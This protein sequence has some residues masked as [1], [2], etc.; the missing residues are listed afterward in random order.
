MNSTAIRS[1]RVALSPAA[2]R[3]V[4]PIKPKDIPRADWNLFVHLN[5]DNNL[6]SFGKADLNEMERV[7]SQKGKFNVFA[8]VDGANG[9]APETG[10]WKQGTRLMW[11]QRDPAKSG[12]IVSREIWVD[13]NSDLGKLLKKGHGELNMGNPAVLNAAL[14]YVQGR[15]PSKSTMVDLWDHGDGWKMASYDESGSELNPV[16][17]EL[18]SALKGVK[19]D[20]LGFDECLMA[21]K[22][23][24][25]I[26]Q[27]AGAKYLVGSEHTEPGEGWNY[28]DFLKRFSNL[29]G[30][31]EPVTADKVAKAA[32]RSYAAGGAKNTQMSATD[33][34]QL[35]SLTRAVDA[36]ADQIFAAGGFKSAAVKDAYENAH[37]GDY[38]PDQ[39]DIGDF[40][41]RLAA[42]V[43]EGPLHDAA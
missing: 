39:M 17:G 10:G 37:R 11:V 30:Q 1:S 15:I 25:D 19:V 23:I 32:V 8:L 36:L 33:L 21:N 4:P 2:P 20:V 7:G 22:E 5:A 35:D 24:A 31:G 14:R 27:K 6:E 26:A 12:K 34:S 40:A 18:A 29:Y 38:D 3:P 16:A 13:P 42:A 28:G 9:Y 41:R 43:P